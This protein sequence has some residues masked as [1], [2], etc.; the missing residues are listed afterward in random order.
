MAGALGAQAGDERCEPANVL[1]AA[2]NPNGGRDRG[3]PARPLKR[4]TV[5]SNDHITL[6]AMISIPSDRRPT[7]PLDNRF[8]RIRSFT[9]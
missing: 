2:E 3:E 6:F 9:P 4:R 1:H 5:I 7:D 8:K